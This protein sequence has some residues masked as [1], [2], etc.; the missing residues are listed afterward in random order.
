MNLTQSGH[1]ALLEKSPELDFQTNGY[2]TDSY[3]A[4]FT[5]ECDF[6]DSLSDQPSHGYPHLQ[7]DAPE[8]NGHINAI[9]FW[10]QNVG[11]VETSEFL[12]VSKFDLTNPVKL[13]ITHSATGGMV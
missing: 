10:N 4:S 1:D 12:L 7:G 9:N 13:A 3:N 5:S 11:N 8:Q 6:L 2:F